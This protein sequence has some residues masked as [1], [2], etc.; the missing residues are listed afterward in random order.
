[1]PSQRYKDH[2]LVKEMRE[3]R[4]RQ[5]RTLVSLGADEDTWLA[6]ERGYNSLRSLRTMERVAKQLGYRIGLIPLDSPTQMS[7]AD[8]V[9]D[10]ASKLEAKA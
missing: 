8:Q 7:L 9:R 6:Y 3:V 4:L 5:G 1:M 2:P 10:L